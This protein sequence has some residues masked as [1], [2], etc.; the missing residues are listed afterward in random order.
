M[1]TDY[2]KENF[3]SAD[4]VKEERLRTLES[5][6]DAVWME[7]E[8]VNQYTG[9]LTRMLVEYSNLGKMLDDV[10][11]VK[12]LFHI[13]PDCF[14]NIMV[15]IEELYDLRALVFEELIDRFKAYEERTQLLLT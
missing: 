14:I 13:M 12:K 11:M 6:F 7:D 9:K 5:K 10:V 4:H 8:L 15:G 1:M 2:L 3:V